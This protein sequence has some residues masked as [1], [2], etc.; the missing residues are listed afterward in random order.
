[1]KFKLKI[2]LLSLALVLCLLFS[3]NVYAEGPSQIIINSVVAEIPADMGSIKEFSGRTFVPVRFLLEYFNYS[4]SWDEEDRIVFGRNL[5]GDVFVM[6]VG[7]PFLTVREDG[8]KS[9]NITM[10]V[11]PVLIAE[12]GR[13]YVPI[14]FLAQAIGYTVGYDDAT[15]TVMLDR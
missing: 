4:V 3:S 5:L 6:Q 1:M 8:K 7:S 2:Q 14:R 11:E 13:T 10:D 12:E 15:G 9:E